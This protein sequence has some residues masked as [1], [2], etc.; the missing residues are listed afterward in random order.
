[1]AR[2][3]QK[4]LWGV[5]FLAAP[6]LMFAQTA[7]PT[8]SVGGGK[9]TAAFSV[10]L[11]AAGGNA[12]YYTLDGSEPT[13]ASARY[14]GPLSISQTSV[15]RAR[16]YDAAN[17]ASFT[18]THT[19]LFNVSHTFPVVCLSFKDGDFFDPATGI[20]P[21]YEKDLTTKC[22][23]EFFEPNSNNASLN[24]AVEVEI[25]GSASATLPQK[26]LE[27]KAKKALGNATMPYQVFK[28]LPYTEYK[29]IV[30]RNAGQD[31]NVMMFRDEFVTSL[32]AD[33]SDLRV[34]LQKPELFASA[35]RPSVVYFNG[36]YWGIHNVRERMKTAFVEQHFN[37]ASTDYDLIENEF[38]TV[39]GDSTV[40]LNFLKYLNSGINFGDNAN[41]D[42]LKQR[43]NYQ[44]YLDY[45]AHNIYIDNEDWPSNNNRRFL[46]K[47]AGSKWQW[48][49][50]DHD[51]SFGL[52]QLTGGFNTGDATPN[53]LRRMVEPGFGG[54]L[55]PA[56]STVLFRKLL[57][58]QQFRFDY[59]NR[60]ADMM[61]TIFSPARLNSRLDQFKN[62]Y[63]PEIAKH[64][65][66]WGNPNAT[67]WEQNIQKTRNFSNNRPAEMR[68]H[69]DEFVQE[70][71][72]SADVTVS[73]S[74]AA[75]G[76]VKFSTI[77]LNQN[78]YPWTGTYFTGVKIPIQATPAAGYRF[79]RWSNGDTNPNTTI[80]FNG[81]LNLQAIFETGNGTN[82]CDNDT[83]LP[84]FAN[85]PTNQTLN[86]VGTCAN[87]TWTAPT[88]SDN[89]STPSVSSN[90]A[91]GNCFNVGTTTVTY[92]ATDAKG[93]RGFCNFNI[94][95]NKTTVNPCDNDTQAPV[96]NNCP[97]NQTLTTTGTCAN[98]SWTAPTASDNCTTPSVSSNF[99]SGFCF[100]VGTTTVTYT[101]TDAKGNKGLCNFT[102]TVNRSTPPTANCTMT[103]KL[104]VET[105]NNTNNECN[106]NFLSTNPSNSTVKT[107]PLFESPTFVADNFGARYRGYVCAPET[108]NY[109]FY[110]ACD[111]GGELNLSTDESVANKRR[112]AFIGSCD[113]APSRDWFK[114]ATQKSVTIALVA[115][116]KYFIEAYFKEITGGDNLAI[117]WS[118]PSNSAIQVI[119]G[120]QFSEYITTPV[121]TGQKCYK[122]LARHSG[123]AMVVESNSTA[124]GVRVVQR[125]YDGSLNHIWR[126][127]GVGSGFYKLSAAH[128]GKSLDVSGVS[129]ANGAILQQYQYGAQA[130]QQWGLTQNSNGSYT[131]K[132]RHSN[133]VADVFQA[134]NNENAAIVQ[135]DNFNYANQQWNIS[136]VG[137]PAGAVQGLRRNATL[138]GGAYR[139]GSRVLVQWAS[140]ADEDDY[141]VVEKVDKNGDYVSLGVINADNANGAET[142]SLHDNQP[143]EGSNFYRIQ[144]NRSGAVPQY[145]E[146]FEVKFRRLADF[147]VYP[148]PANDYIDINI[149]A[150]ERGKEIGVVLI[151]M[152][153]KVAKYQKFVE[154]QSKTV[155]LELENI[156]DGAYF[157]HIEMA[158]KRKITRPVVIMR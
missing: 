88:A 156:E 53:A 104:L 135:Y 69:V 30:L 153:G 43:I 26:S 59:V 111:N 112:I 61:N 129:Q 36:K 98:A 147:E 35:Y 57:Q 11:S 151:S 78:N 152:D 13:N 42:Q 89:C 66:R 64:A 107:L 84:V 76:S 95:V 126:I 56:W 101:A 45:N 55:T 131:I 93:N 82:P 41:F 96:F 123:K 58:N 62:V 22:N 28:D 119:P 140:N 18:T 5:L 23:V 137:C 143:E 133:K 15:L 105:W 146:V 144:M 31:W 149:E 4:L 132:A 73:A 34:S 97:A 90:F 60:T 120:S 91:S 20:Y 121:S 155:R 134:S 65:T 108:G 114:Y 150:A 74:P 117:G 40:W 145:S 75:G 138:A 124:N 54:R 80:D 8:A 10:S 87:A 48:L 38:K 77:S 27:L 67:I 12:I 49:N 136:E 16:A 128:S 157:I 142:Y 125:T 109:T 29:R 19:Y 139:D 85:C 81:A 99:A 118:K 44:N 83:Q 113:W 92:T 2:Q 24:Q 154:P 25:Q 103:S 86:T 122:I 14:G 39:N 110:I 47:A 71:T 1:M 106:F 141:F 9:F 6:F 72:G 100:N 115:G 148:N 3:L 7:Q 51:F 17:V 130:N 50:F 94:T 46:G 102:V 52:F 37:L 158:G 33:L 79:V 70:V 68:K 63:A 32:F 116:Q 127:L 21:N